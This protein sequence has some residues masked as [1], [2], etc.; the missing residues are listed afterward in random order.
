MKGDKYTANVEIVI[1]VEFVDDGEN[2][3]A[4]Q[5][6]DAAAAYYSEE[7]SLS[8]TVVDLKEAA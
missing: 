5:A 1:E 2:N 7:A 8:A 3:L 4:D 6:H